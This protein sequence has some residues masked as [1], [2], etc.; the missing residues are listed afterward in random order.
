MRELAIHLPL[1]ER[2]LAIS[3]PDDRVKQ[4]VAIEITQCR[5]C[6]RADIDTVKWTTHGLEKHDATAFRALLL[7]VEIK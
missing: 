6:I 7:T 4:T 3:V 2:Q 1:Q 5:G